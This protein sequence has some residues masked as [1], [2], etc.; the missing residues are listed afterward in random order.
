MRMISVRELLAWQM[1]SALKSQLVNNTRDDFQ[2]HDYSAFYLQLI[3]IKYNKQMRGI[4]AICCFLLQPT[5]SAPH[6]DR[7][8]LSRL[9]GRPAQERS[10]GGMF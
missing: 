3:I 1:K 5:D 8:R 9:D 6:C 7:S 10:E 4:E 2:K